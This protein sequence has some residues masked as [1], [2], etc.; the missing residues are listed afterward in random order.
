MS[1]FVET[2][3]CSRIH[4]LFL[5]AAVQ[6]EAAVAAL[7]EQDVRAAQQTRVRYMARMATLQSRL[8]IVV[9]KG[10]YDEP[11][12]SRIFCITSSMP[13]DDMISPLR[14]QLMHDGKAKLIV[15]SLANRYIPEAEVVDVEEVEEVEGGEEGGEE[16]GG[17]VE[18]EEEEGEGEEEEE[19]EVAAPKRQR[20][21]ALQFEA[22]VDSVRCKSKAVVDAKPGVKRA[23]RKK[24]VPAGCVSRLDKI[25]PRTGD[26]YKREAYNMAGAA[27]RK[28]ETVTA[29]AVASAM[30]ISEARHELELKLQ[31]RESEIGSLNLQLQAAKEEL[32]CFGV[33]LDKA[34]AAAKLKERSKVAEAVK[35]ATY[36]GMNAAIRLMNK[37]EVKSS[38]DTSSAHKLPKNK[39]VTPPS[40]MSS[41]SDGY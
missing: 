12:E 39:V 17:G 36:D 19:A 32:K 20:R 37:K 38:S 13:M 4:K 5:N 25:D 40:P 26:L 21:K 10:A 22:A 30:L 31:A 18:E 23:P 8:D 11:F 9:S 33:K 27:I 29:S 6:L 28:P 24:P 15:T 1:T 3:L 41:D 2:K 14:L 7:A 16:G 35:M 34:V